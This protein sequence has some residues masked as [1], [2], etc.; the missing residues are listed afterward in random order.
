MRP[1]K[2]REREEGVEVKIVVETEGAWLTVVHPR[3]PVVSLR[4][5]DLPKN[6]YGPS[7]RLGTSAL[8]GHTTSSC[9]MACMTA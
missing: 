2:E 6:L 4:S 3:M 7:T 1:A 9:A 5:S 8:V